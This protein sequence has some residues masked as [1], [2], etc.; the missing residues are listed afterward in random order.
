MEINKFYTLS[1]KLTPSTFQAHPKGLKKENERYRGS[2]D[3]HCLIRGLYDGIEFPIIFE[4]KYGKKLLD[5]IDTGYA[6]L[7]LISGRFKELLETNEFTGW[8]VYNVEVF[9]KLGKQI[10]G[11]YGLSVIGKCGPIDYSKSQIIKKQ[12]VPNGKFSEYYKGKYIGLDT[13]DKSSLFLPEDNNGII[14]TEEVS[15][16][17]KRNKL[18]NV[19]L[20]NLADYEI[21]TYAVSTNTKLPKKGF[22]GKLGF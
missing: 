17:I 22:L 9:D 2:S 20:K 1:S 12:L 7:Y 3:S 6:S 4:Q 16:V 19:S 14:V 21:A 8:K 15:K 13:W 11:Y 5:I 18:S 10:F